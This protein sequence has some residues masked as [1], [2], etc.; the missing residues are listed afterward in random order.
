MRPNREAILP[1][2]LKAAMCRRAPLG[3]CDRQPVLDESAEGLR[4]CRSGTSQ[5]L[6]ATPRR[7]GRGN[8]GGVETA[9]EYLG[10]R[11]EAAARALGVEAPP[12]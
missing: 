1:G 5:S 8:R 11:R 7:A 2:T 10:D 3:A 12:I 4:G 6:P 9:P